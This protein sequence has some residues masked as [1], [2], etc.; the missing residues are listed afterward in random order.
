MTEQNI[1][2]IKMRREDRYVQKETIKFTLN[3][4]VQIFNLIQTLE[5]PIFFLKNEVTLYYLAFITSI[6]LKICC[7]K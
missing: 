6:N 3:L 5:A 7:L 2:G 4:Y 1:M